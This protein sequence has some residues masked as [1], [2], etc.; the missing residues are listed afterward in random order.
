[1]YCRSEK[2]RLEIHKK[3]LSFRKRRKI[4]LC[5]ILDCIKMAMEGQ[6]Y[7]LFHLCWLPKW[8]RVI[9]GRAGMLSAAHPLN[10]A[11][12]SLPLKPQQNTF[13]RWS[14]NIELLGELV[15]HSST[16]NSSVCQ[17]ANISEQRIN[18][19]CKA[20]GTAPA[21]QQITKREDLNDLSL[22]YYWILIINI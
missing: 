7:S 8:I 4:T 17:S 11:C 3:A 15:H 14:Q 6:I 18:K 1:M 22:F 9:K 20:K 5:V 19:T 10:A 16:P 2:L 21:S 12:I 13:L